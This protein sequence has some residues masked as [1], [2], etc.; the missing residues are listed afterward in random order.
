[1]N[2]NSHKHTLGIIHIIYGSLIGLSF[3]FIGVIVNSLTPF[4]TEVIQEENG[5]GGAMVFEVV[6]RIIRV[7]FTLIFIFSG[8]P[9]IIGGIGL[10]QKKAWGMLITIIAGCVSIFSFPFGTALGIYTIFVFTQDNKA[11]KHDQNQG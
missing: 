8:L 9:S 11:K 1:M 6:S 10:L 3:V 5:T 7:V 4:I 2:I